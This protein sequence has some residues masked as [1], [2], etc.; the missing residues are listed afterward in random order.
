VWT[1]IVVLIFAAFAGGALCG[2][3]LRVWINGAE[4]EI[5][6][7]R[8][9]ARRIEADLHLGKTASKKD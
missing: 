1:L 3:K 6:D 8:D 4:A 2:P 9:R 5:L 7:L